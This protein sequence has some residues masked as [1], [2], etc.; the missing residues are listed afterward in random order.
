MTIKI[1]PK[2]YY[3]RVT[4]DADGMPDAFHGDFT[5]K[6]KT[7][8]TASGSFGGNNQYLFTATSPKNETY[9]QNGKL[10]QL[11][12]FTTALTVDLSTNFDT[13]MVKVWKF[14]DKYDL[15]LASGAETTVG[16][17][18]MVAFSSIIDYDTPN[19]I[20]LFDG[21]NVA[22]GQDDNYD[23][24]VTTT[25]EPQYGLNWSAVEQHYDK[26]SSGFLVDLKPKSGQK[27]GEV[28][29]LVKSDKNNGKAFTDLYTIYPF[30][31]MGGWGLDS[32]NSMR[33]HRTLEGWNEKMGPLVTIT[34][35][36]TTTEN[37]KMQS[38]ETFVA[39]A[40]T[41]NTIFNSNYQTND[42]NDIKVQT[43]EGSGDDRES[44]AYSNAEFST[45]DYVEGGQSL[46][47][48]SF[49]EN[50]SGATATSD[51]DKIRANFPGTGSSGHNYPQEVTYAINHL[52]EF[53]PLELGSGSSSAPHQPQKPSIC[54]EIEM[55]FKI[56][57]MGPAVT[58]KS[59]TSGIES[60]NMLRSFNIVLC[61][62]AHQSGER[63]FDYIFR[64][65]DGAN[66][67]ASTAAMLGL[68]IVRN[69]QNDDTVRVFDY[70]AML[71]PESAGSY[72]SDTNVLQRSGVP[73]SFISLP[74]DEWI[75]AKFKID[76]DRNSQIVYF[77]SH[78]NTNGEYKSLGLTFIGPSGQP[79]ISGVNALNTMVVNSSNLRSI[80]V[81]DDGSS[82]TAFNKDLM[83]DDA[84]DIDI[85]QM[86]CIDSIKLR[87]VN[88]QVNNATYNPNNI[89]P[90]VLEIPGA[91]S[92]VPKGSDST[93][94][95]E[96]S[97]SSNDNYFFNAGM[98]V[99]SFLSFGFDSEPTTGKR[100]LLLSTF[101]SISPSP[102]Q[103]HKN[104]TKFGFSRNDGKV[105][106]LDNNSFAASG[107][108]GALSSPSSGNYP[109]ISIAGQAN[110]IEGFR[111]KGNLNFTL[112][113]RDTEWG[114][115]DIWTRRENPLVQSRVMSM[116]TDGYNVIVDNIGIFKLASG[117]RYVAYHLG[118][119]F[120]GISNAKMLGKDD[121]WPLTVVEIDESK[122]SI[123]FSRSLNSITA[124]VQHI[125][126]S[127]YKYWLNCALFN[128]IPDG[129]MTDTGQWGNNWY[130]QAEPTVR[131]GPSRTYKAARYL[132][133]TG[134]YG[135]TYN[136][137]LYSDR[138]DY[139]N[140]WRLDTDTENSAV[141]NDVDYGF[142]VYQPADSDGKEEKRL[143]HVA[144]HL[145]VS[146]ANFID[147]S[148]VTSKDKINRNE[149]ITF[150]MTPFKEYDRTKYN[151]TLSRKGFSVNPVHRIN[152][153][154][155]PKLIFGYE[156]EIPVISDFS[157]NPSFD[158][159]KQDVDIDGLAK[160]ANNITFRWRESKTKPWY[161]MLIVD[162]KHIANKYHTMNFY[163]PLDEEPTDYN[164]RISRANPIFYT[165]YANYPNTPTSFD[166][167]ATIPDIEGFAGYGHR[168]VASSAY[169]PALTG[170]Q[171]AFGSTDAFTFG[172]HV[173]PSN[174]N[175]TLFAVSSSHLSNTANIFEV[176]IN[177]SKQVVVTVAS[178]SSTATL[179]TT[180][181]Y[182]CNGEQ[183]LAIYTTYNKNR[184]NNNLKLYVNGQLEDTADY[185]TSFV[186][187]G[188][189]SI[190]MQVDGT[191]CNTGIYNE[192]FCLQTESFIV[193]SN[194]FIL[195]TKHL[196]DVTSGK[197]YNYQSRLFAFDY[198]NV[199]GS[200]SEEVGT[201]SVEGWKVTGLN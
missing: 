46:F 66:S 17:D 32:G 126:I 160:N 146:G 38:E 108:T 36:S 190:N 71:D 69:N 196:P 179:T 188:C 151:I 29:P 90:D 185:T 123:R 192:I 68:G 120:S 72:I 110:D 83:A 12:L 125:A 4:F 119:N 113:T 182:E 177:S 178:G 81:D 163:A 25:I 131:Y 115:T 157:A 114:D 34:T 187:S 165:S 159:L 1:E 129:G 201:S 52:P 127:P 49:W 164:E 139:V 174:S 152:G 60:F 23:K 181:T 41:E 3:K 67:F 94:L 162:S 191:D 15:T 65:T 76:F 14:Q 40:N 27:K 112:G 101:Q 128:A 39:K 56:K 166:H 5:I 173:K 53:I 140:L 175:N 107:G 7:A 183:P 194:K 106:I 93:T 145:L 105:G 134:S 199:K 132:T 111:Q 198:H 37:V 144:R 33:W 9:G 30:V 189:V 28:I 11:Y 75:T 2:T 61:S 88:H 158:L 122:S 135:T 13:P 168:G 89:V 102:Q 92:N 156:T 103:I 20:E 200:S 136:E 73:G 19:I 82:G 155:D 149:G 130:R 43:L 141:V 169:N 143:G 96:R 117:S 172:M 59:A 31:Y 137:T 99:C 170:S 109:E 150:M 58:G 95:S 97:L 84:T 44:F 116:S 74:L 86:I 154:L 10:N 85:K 42:W 138:A 184:D 45:D 118:E 148:G 26:G 16:D 77:P 153:G 48:N 57:S 142:G 35:G 91:F 100:A 133:A 167:G 63:F 54:G 79:T 18:D 98:P 62:E 51:S 78:P 180:D 50:Y 171:T 8:S 161:R 186:A 21:R 104:Y 195:D 6:G 193:P 124:D 64:V 147:L 197:S 55:V 22:L 121:A 176:K 80:N 24:L 87:N 47:F 70:K